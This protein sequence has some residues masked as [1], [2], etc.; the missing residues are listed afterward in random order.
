MRSIT[1]NI[2]FVALEQA[3][4]YIKGFI[5]L[6]IVS[7]HYI[8]KPALIIL[9]NSAEISYALTSILKLKPFIHQMRN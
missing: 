2:V 6:F 8:S 4:V 1:D 7:A 3:K 5:L 9:P